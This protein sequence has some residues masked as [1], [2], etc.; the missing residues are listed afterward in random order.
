MIKAIDTYY[1][2]YYF[3]SRTEARWAVFFDVMRIRYEYEKEGFVLP[4]GKYL[5]DFWLPNFSA[6]SFAE[7]KGVAFTE[8]ER[9][10]C[11]EL[12]EQSHNDVIMLDGPPDFKSYSLFY[13]LPVSDCFFCNHLSAFNASVEEFSQENLLRV[14]MDF[15]CLLKADHN[16]AAQSY[17][18][19]L[20]K[21]I[22]Q[23]LFIIKVESN[24]CA[25]FIQSELDKCKEYIKRQF[26]STR[27]ECDIE[28]S[29]GTLLENICNQISQRQGVQRIIGC[30]FQESGLIK[31]C[32][33][34]RHW[35]TYESKG[36][37]GH[38]NYRG[39][40]RMCLD[41]C[42]ED[43]EED[44]R[45]NWSPLYVDAV[46]AARSARFEFIHKS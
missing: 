20:P 45:L 16:P 4:S 27:I 37:L 33:Q 19:A 28:T 44:F 8:D 11:R 30:R 15:A 12:C 32:K 41:K 13:D 26:G 34:T 35:E 9:T 17:C 21:V 22:S 46:Y 38:K 5:P 39:G 2:G 1:N 24:L 3:R 6:G 18:D 25:R 23:N 31:N 14:W 7:V 43:N 36:L 40:E 10:R 29:Q 42:L